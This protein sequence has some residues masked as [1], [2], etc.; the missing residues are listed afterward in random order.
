M[1]YTP[2]L[3]FTAG[4]RFVKAGISSGAIE[5]VGEISAATHAPNTFAVHVEGVGD[6]DVSAVRGGVVSAA[7][8]GV[9]EIAAHNH[10]PNTFALSVEGRGA[11]TVSTGGFVAARPTTGG[12]NAISGFDD[13]TFAVFIPRDSLLASG[14][15][16]RVRIKA[17]SD[18]MTL[19]PVAIGEVVGS[20]PFEYLGAPTEFEFAGS[21]TKV[22]AAGEVAVS[23]PLEFDLPPAT[24]GRH[25]LIRMYNADSA[26]PWFVWPQANMVGR[27]VAGNQVTTVPGAAGLEAEA[28]AILGF[29]GLDV[30][31]DM[32]DA[33]DP[34]GEDGES[35]TFP[36]G[37]GD[38][39]GLMS[40]FWSQ[41]SGGS[42]PT[43][44]LI[45]GSHESVGVDYVGTGGNHRYV[46]DFGSSRVVTEA[47]YYQSDSAEHGTWQWSGSDD[48]DG[49]GTVGTFTP[50]GTTFVLGGSTL[51]TLTELSAN[52]TAYRYYK[53]EK[54]SGTIDGAS[55][56]LEFEFSI[57]GE[58]YSRPPVSVTV[59]G[60]GEIVAEVEAMEAE[61]VDAYITDFNTSDEGGWGGYT[62]ALRISGAA[63]MATGG[64][65]RVLF[66]SGTGTIPLPIESAAI[67]IAAETGDGYDFAGTPVSLTFGGNPGVEI[68]SGPNVVESDEAVLTVD[69]IADILIRARHVSGSSDVR[70]GTVAGNAA[71]VGSWY[72]SG[73]HV[74]TVDASSFSSDTTVNAI[75]GLQVRD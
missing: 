16:I 6:I 23:D 12:Q 48:D 56:A 25:L 52:A 51:Q 69:G 45:D 4:E 1:F 61:W 66:S 64:K 17:G 62:F 24:A 54:L 30:I 36:L 50:I 38:R 10:P 49:T 8:E 14:N 9:G 29:V 27:Y 41:T 57:D 35:F 55:N 74:T 42:Q 60:V 13:K 31:A 2:L 21:S 15:V 43:D 7:V 70:R 71:V 5:G 73:D 47:R 20:H 39:R 75:A 46:F 59:D 33:E 68:P 37:A 3:L 19:G 72:R 58:G 53:M 40:V 44:N 67:G 34:P 63:L 26:K 22:L 28:Q 65:V 18:G 11:I 32:V